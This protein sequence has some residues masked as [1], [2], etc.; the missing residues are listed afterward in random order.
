MKLRDTKLGHWLREKA[1]KVLDAVGDLL[2][3]KGVLGIVK[4]LVSGS[5]IPQEDKLEFERNW[6]LFEIEIMTLEVDD[7]KSARTRE[8][9]F[10]KATGHLDRFML[11][12]GLFVILAFA[13][14]MYVTVYLTLPEASREMFIE[15]RATTRDA[16]ITLIVYYWGSSAGSRIKD[17]KK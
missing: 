1:P 13:F 7:R 16:L 15:V 6:Q 14:C 4:N 11:I 12:L 2:P 3:E 5:D 9:D 17:M 8:T 10:I